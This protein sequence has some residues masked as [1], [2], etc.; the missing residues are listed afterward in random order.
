MSAGLYGITAWPPKAL[1]GFVEDFQAQHGVQA[2]GQPHFNLR[3]PFL[4]AGTEEEL[5][6]RFQTCARI[7]RF[8]AWIDGWADFPSALYIA[9]RATAE[10]LEAH[11]RVLEVGGAPLYAGLDQHDYVPHV[12]VA[13]GLTDENR[14]RIL[15]ATQTHPIPRRSWTVSHLAL[16]RDENGTLLGLSTVLLAATMTKNR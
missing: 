10:V 12:T 8:R 6:E 3:Y 13:L 9:I 16:T 15:S 5:I 4:W 14:Q 2:Y 1:T 11:E 7:P